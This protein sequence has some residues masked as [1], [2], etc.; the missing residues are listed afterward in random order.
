MATCRAAVITAHE[1]PLK[2]WDVNV[3]IL[4]PGSVLI[5]WSHQTYVELM[6]TDGM[7]HFPKTRHYKQLIF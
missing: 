2:I 3:P 4:D 6:S 1:K 5:K 7:G